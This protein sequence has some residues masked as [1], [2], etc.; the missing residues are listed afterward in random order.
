MEQNTVD[1]EGVSI[2]ICQQNM[3]GDKR[4][5]ETS[6]SVSDHGVLDKGD[7]GLDFSKRNILRNNSLVHLD[8]Q[9]V[10]VD[11]YKLTEEKASALKH[12]GYTKRQVLAWTLLQLVCLFYNIFAIGPSPCIVFYSI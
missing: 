12:K 1:T 3:E 5:S 10:D 7:S 9:T 2:E 8:R 4:K 6:S 11:I